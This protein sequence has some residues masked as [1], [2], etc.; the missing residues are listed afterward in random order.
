MITKEE[1]TEEYLERLLHLLF[2][3]RIEELEWATKLLEKVSDLAM[4]RWDDD[5]HGLVYEINGKI[6]E[7]I[8]MLKKKENSSHELHRGGVLTK[9]PLS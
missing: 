4:K 8:I 7:R 1:M 6:K 3:S 9:E 5:L 2:R